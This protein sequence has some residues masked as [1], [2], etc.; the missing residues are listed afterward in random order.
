[1]KIVGNIFNIRFRTNCKHEFKQNK[2][3]WKN[4]QKSRN[5]NKD[6]NDHINEGK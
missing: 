1:M 4:Q 2:K 3:K 6:N 5:N